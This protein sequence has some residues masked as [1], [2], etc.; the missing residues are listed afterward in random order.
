MP[1]KTKLSLSL[2]RDNYAVRTRHGKQKVAALGNANFCQRV[3]VFL[4]YI[5]GIGEIN[6]PIGY[7]RNYQERNSVLNLRWGLVVSIG[8]AYACRGKSRPS[9]VFG[10]FKRYLL[11]NADLFGTTLF[12]MRIIPSEN[13]RFVLVLFDFVLFDEPLLF[14]PDTLQQSLCRLVRRVLRYQLAPGLPLAVSTS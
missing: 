12:I 8:N 2:Y 14:R 6:Y 5:T 13:D 3:E 9:P 7:I 4:W 11:V 1:L 10:D